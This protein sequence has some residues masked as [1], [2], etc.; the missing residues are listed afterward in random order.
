[1]GV[2]EVVQ[3]LAAGLLDE[4]R[5]EDCDSPGA[6]LGSDLADRDGGFDGGSEEVLRNA[7]GLEQTPVCEH[8]LKPYAFSLL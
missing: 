2:Q 1:V 3:G 6:A 8:P 4:V 7:L 5:R